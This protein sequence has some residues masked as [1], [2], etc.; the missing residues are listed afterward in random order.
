LWLTVFLKAAVELK[1]IN[2][3]KTLKKKYQGQT[4]RT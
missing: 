4:Y 1:T 2:Y 3:V